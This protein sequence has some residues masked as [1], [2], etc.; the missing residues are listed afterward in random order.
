MT[1]YDR[2]LSLS[3]NNVNKYLNSVFSRPY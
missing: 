1:A 3:A 2:D